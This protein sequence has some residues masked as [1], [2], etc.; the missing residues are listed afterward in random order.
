MRDI[1]LVGAGGG[2]GAVLRLQLSGWISRTLLMPTFPF[3]TACV[4]L[5]GCLVIGILTGVAERSS[6]LNEDL[7]LLLFTGLLGGFTT[8]SAFGI[9]TFLLIRQEQ[10]VSAS[11]YVL[12]SVLGGLLLV[13]LGYRLVTS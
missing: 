13:W 12:T 3:G 8:F 7:R 6:F 9:E 1:L 4:N 2:L 10:I 11:I 5:T